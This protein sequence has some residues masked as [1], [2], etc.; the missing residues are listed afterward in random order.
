MFSILS[1]VG[2]ISLHI[3]VKIKT[4]CKL[5]LYENGQ[6]VHKNTFDITEHQRNANQNRN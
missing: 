5:Y 2:V 1:V 4:V 6:Q 3:F